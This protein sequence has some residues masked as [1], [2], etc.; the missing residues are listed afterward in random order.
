MA[1]INSIV[2]Y[3]SEIEVKIN[4]KLSQED[5][6][7]RNWG[8]DDLLPVRSLIRNF[9]RNE[10]TAICAFC[11]EPVSIISALNCHVEHIVPKSIHLKFIFIPK[12]LCVVCADCNTIK[13]EQETLNEIPETLKNTDAK[14]YPRTSDSFKIVHPHFD[15]YNE[16][17]LIKNGFYVDR[18]MK[19]HFTIGAC[20]LN[21]KL[22]T[23]GYEITK[24]KDENLQ[25]LMFSYL[26]QDNQLEKNR[27]F[28]E[29]EKVFAK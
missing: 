7:H 26:D 2:V 4:N 29:L 17:I 3:T 15:N 14:I 8:D 5:F 12:N 22:H 16:H 24:E 28:K 19:G 25:E 18:T 13:R 9:Y 11:K 23:F 10:Q 21:R 6:N 1:D 20:K 27:I